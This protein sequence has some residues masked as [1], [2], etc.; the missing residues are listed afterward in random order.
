MLELNKKPADLWKEPKAY[1]QPKVQA[2]DMAKH[3]RLEAANQVLEAIASHGRK[4]FRDRDRSGPGRNGES[5]SRF[6]LK[7]NT[8]YFEDC[9]PS[10]KDGSRPLIPVLNPRSDWRGF[11]EGGTL[12]NVVEVLAQFIRGYRKPSDVYWEAK[13][14][15]PV[16]DTRLHPGFIC[17]RFSWENADSSNVW[18]YSLEA[19]AAL[20][21]E[22][23]GN[24]A[25]RPIDWNTP[26]PQEATA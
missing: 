14:E 23:K 16:I 13:R 2:H 11:S 4:F 20:K 3:E 21:A 22:L 12:K 15:E 19:E 8:L 9:Y 1:P 18:G 5:V 26:E 7:G 17:G 6:I 10:G 24:P 25:L